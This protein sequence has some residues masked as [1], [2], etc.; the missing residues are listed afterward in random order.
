MLSERRD[1][2]RVRREACRLGY[3]G[4]LNAV[5]KHRGCAGHPHRA[6]VFSRRHSGK[7]PE[8]LQKIES[9][10]MHSRRYLRAV[11]EILK[12]DIPDRAVYPLVSGRSESLHAVAET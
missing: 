11:A 6:R 4:Y 7:P 10:E 12:A 8:Q 5:A 1:K 2:R 3:P 9:V